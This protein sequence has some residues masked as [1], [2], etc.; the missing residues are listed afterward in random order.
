MKFPHQHDVPLTAQEMDALSARQHVAAALELSAGSPRPASSSSSASSSARPSTSAAAS[1]LALLPPPS[2]HS[3]GR[4]QRRKKNWVV[5]TSRRPVVDDAP[6]P[7]RFGTSAHDSLGVFMGVSAVLVRV[8]AGCVWCGPAALDGEV[9]HAWATYATMH[10][11]LR[12]PLCTLV[13]CGCSLD[14]NPTPRSTQPPTSTSPPVTLPPLLLS[15]S[16]PARPPDCPPLGGTE[17]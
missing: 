17:L 10:V 12:Q 7:L 13:T 1:G 16:P 3:S 2:A 5:A 6:Q 4:G 11:H 8:G 9:P 15:P 14:A